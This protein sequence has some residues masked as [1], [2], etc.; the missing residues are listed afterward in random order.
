MEQKS[1]FE[2]IVMLRHAVVCHEM[3]IEFNHVEQLQ[4]HFGS[5][6]DDILCRSQ[7][8]RMNASR[9]CPLSTKT[10]NLHTLASGYIQWSSVVVE[11]G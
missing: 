3:I 7:G 6:V 4:K 1:F 10:N 11:A 5:H 8:Q 2:S 9:N